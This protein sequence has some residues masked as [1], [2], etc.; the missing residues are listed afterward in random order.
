[1]TFTKQKGVV[2]RSFL[3]SFI[4]LGGRS[5]GNKEVC[6]GQISFTKESQ[7]QSLH[8]STQG[9]ASKTLPLHRSNLRLSENAASPLQ[10]SSGERSIPKKFL[11]CWYCSPSHPDKC[12][13]PSLYSWNQCYCSCLHKTCVRRKK[14][15]RP[16]A[17]NPE[18][19]RTKVDSGFFRVWS[20]AC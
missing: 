20:L 14:E 6:D 12:E 10:Q 18:I 17:P 16:W 4:A 8:A 9:T 13:V 7:W 15:E 2:N 3:F 19:L 1:M 11:W 5:L